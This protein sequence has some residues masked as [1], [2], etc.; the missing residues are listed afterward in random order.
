[1]NTQWNNT[2]RSQ[3]KGEPLLVSCQPVK[4]VGQPPTKR[5]LEQCKGL[6]LNSVF[7][8][9]TH[10]GLFKTKTYHTATETCAKSSPPPHETKSLFQTEFPPSHTPR[11][12][13]TGTPMS[14]QEAQRNA[15]QCTLLLLA[16][17]YQLVMSTCWQSS[18]SILR[19]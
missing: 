18:S 7:Y 12:H 11:R 1:M 4:F 16:S 5:G 19:H 14:A 9:D 10:R 3:K 6:T 13:G 2:L 8:L 15:R 17:I